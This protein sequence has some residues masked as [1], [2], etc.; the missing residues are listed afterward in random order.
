MIAKDVY[1]DI[2]FL[3]KYYFHLFHTILS[4]IFAIVQI[5]GSMAF[6]CLLQKSQ[7]FIDVDVRKSFSI[8]TCSR[9]IGV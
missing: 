9:D 3:I 1:L 6:F 4:D 5:V 7:Y 2:Q 8:P